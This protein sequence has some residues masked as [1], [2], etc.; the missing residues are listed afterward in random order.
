MIILP[1][2]RWSVVLGG[3]A[4]DTVLTLD[5]RTVRWPGRD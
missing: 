1:Y 5:I 3:L 4:H 2:E